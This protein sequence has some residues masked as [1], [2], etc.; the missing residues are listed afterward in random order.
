M[1]SAPW[2]AIGRTSP[3]NPHPTRVVPFVV[4]GST[5]WR[6]KLVEGIGGAVGG[7]A[8]LAVAG[9]PGNAAEAGWIGLGGLIVGLSV[10]L[11]VEYVLHL[12]SEVNR[13][14]NIERECQDE[15]A[16][17]D[18]ERRLWEQQIAA[19]KR[20]A[21]ATAIGSKVWAGAYREAL[22]TGHAPPLAAVEARFANETEAAN[23]APPPQ[24]DPPQD[25]SPDAL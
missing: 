7:L 13:L 18:R 20:E 19:A 17:R 16:Q 5:Q 15:R 25:R 9:W 23:L 22:T 8:A 10:V 3:K 6:S 1:L 24:H 4:V 21:T 2:C 12:R 11:G 14:Q